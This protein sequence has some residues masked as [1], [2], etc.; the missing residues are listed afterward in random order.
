MSPGVGV[1]A[2]LVCGRRVGVGVSADGT[3]MRTTFSSNGDGGGGDDNGDDGGGANEM[4]RQNFPLP[5]SLRAAA[6]AGMSS[7]R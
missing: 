4:H 2:R 7:E 1:S 6:Q 3:L 5:G